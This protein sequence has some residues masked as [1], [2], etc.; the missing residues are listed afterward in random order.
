M[1]FMVIERFKDANATLVVERFRYSG[2][3]LLEGVAYHASWVDLEGARCFQ[4]YGSSATGIAEPLGQPL[5]EP[6]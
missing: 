1:L 4:V 2:R 5:A 3:M 6:D